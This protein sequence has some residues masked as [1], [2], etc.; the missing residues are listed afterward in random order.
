MVIL[1]FLFLV[2][3]FILWVIGIYNRLVSLRMRVK[4]AWSQ[5]D[6]QLKRRH[7]LIP[8]LVE[9]VK[10]YMKYERETLERVMEARAKALG[11]STLAEK[12]KAE[13]ELT[14]WLTRLFAL[15]ENYPELKANQNV[16]HLQEQLTTTENQIAF[17]RQHYNDSVMRYRVGTQTFPANIIA[18]MF[19]FGPEE[20]FETPEAEKAAPKV[21]LTIS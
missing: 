12:A 5:I 9:A 8:N 16:L 10:G 4:N 1:I 2:V 15:F 14:G 19:G 13:G 7:D 18:R 21:D 20:F 17:S 6:V 11:A 3:L